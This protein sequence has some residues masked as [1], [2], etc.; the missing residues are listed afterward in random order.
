MMD[1]NDILSQYNDT[2]K[3]FKNKTKDSVIRTGSYDR[4]MLIETVFSL[5][6]ISENLLNATYPSADVIA[7]ACA[8]KTEQVLENFLP[9]CSS[10]VT[11]KIPQRSP[12]ERVLIVENSEAD[13]GNF[14]NEKWTDVVN[15]KI[16][17][18]LKN[19]PVV[20]NVVNR[21]GK[22]CL[23]LPSE[24]SLNEAKNALQDDFNVKT[25]EKKVNKIMPR[26]KIHN[27]NVSDCESK[28]QLLEMILTKNSAIRDG[29]NGASTEKISVTYLDKTRKYAVLKVIPKLREII[30]KTSK[31][32]VGLESLYVSDYYHVV[33][34][35]QCQEFGH[36]C[37]S[38][39]CKRKETTPVCLYCAGNH[40]SSECNKKNSK[41]NHRCSNC[42]NS[43]TFNIRSKAKSHTA[44]SKDCPIYQRE[45]ERMKQAT[46]YDTKN[47]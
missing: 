18:K 13:D 11:K 21:S 5:M 37:D 9:K 19:I 34:C 45:F 15:R 39:K 17:K 7:Q 31:I 43:S 30:M 16:S 27:L 2:I 44:S 3:V 26:L 25:Q 40:R 32:F 41:E 38:E 29:I 8:V 10:P 14:T 47:E 4:K 24:D 20:K 35:F 23:I 12:D 1:R 42:T 28:E 33:R 6:N 22:G 46:D 36:I